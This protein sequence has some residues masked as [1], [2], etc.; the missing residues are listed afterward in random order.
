MILTFHLVTSKN[1]NIIFSLRNNTK[2]YRHTRSGMEEEDGVEP[3]EMSVCN[4]QRS[5]ETCKTKE[6]DLM[7][8]GKTEV[9]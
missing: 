7:R 2:F 1:V 5:L 9:L 3:H 8:I 4:K 6:T